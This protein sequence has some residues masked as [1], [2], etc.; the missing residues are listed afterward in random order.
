M[1]NSGTYHVPP[2]LIIKI[3]KFRIADALAP[4]EPY[5]DEDWTPEDRKNQDSIY[6]KDRR[7]LVKLHR[8]C[9]YF[10]KILPELLYEKLNIKSQNRANGLL[11]VIQNPAT[12][13]GAFAGKITHL[14][15]MFAISSSHSWPTTS[16]ILA[17]T[18]SVTTLALGF[19]A[20]NPYFIISLT[21]FVETSLPPN[22]NTLVLRM[23]T[24]ETPIDAMVILGYLDNQTWSHTAWCQFFTAIP[25]ISTFA[26]QTIQFIVWPPLRH[27]EIHLLR[28]WL[29]NCKPALKAVELIYGHSILNPALHVVLEHQL[30]AQA[31]AALGQHELLP[32]FIL[33]SNTMKVIGIHSSNESKSINPKSNYFLFSR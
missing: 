14:E 30:G 18:P 4:R 11:S 31:F 20:Q 16:A 24:N 2:E 28:M 8:V 13:T 3:L 19:S 6:A 21:K 27:A 33:K 9:S 12:L 10:A 5:F 1:N 32:P 26:L 25:H 7:D 15:F 29:T 17:L 23:I 22:V